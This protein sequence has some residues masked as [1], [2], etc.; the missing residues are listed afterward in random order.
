MIFSF[1]YHYTHVI[2]TT[3]WYCSNSQ[4]DGSLEI[5]ALKG[6]D[7]LKAITVTRAMSDLTSWLA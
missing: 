6:S 5:P 4:K 1:S 2:Q 7:A 3:H